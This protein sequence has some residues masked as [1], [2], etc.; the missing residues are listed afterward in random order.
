MFAVI[1]WLLSGLLSWTLLEYVIH[2]ILSHQLQSF[3]T[4]LHAVHHRDQ[5]AVFALGAWPPAVALMAAMVVGWGWRPLSV[6]YLGLLAGF[7]GYEIIHYRL[8]FARTLTPWEARLRLHHR[9]HHLISPNRCFGV[10]TTLWDC[11]LGT[12]IGAAERRRYEVLL[13]LPP[14]SGPSNLGQL[15]A[16]LRPRAR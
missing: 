3:V 14:L 10:S 11:A 5:H 9:I 4:P 13:E 1:A 7:A 15:L 8:H 6:F 16:E 2:G 12:G